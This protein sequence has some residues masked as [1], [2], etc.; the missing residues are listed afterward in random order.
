MAEACTRRVIEKLE[1]LLFTN[2]SYSFGG[3]TIY[4]YI[5]F[6]NNNDV[7]LSANWDAAGKTGAQILTDV[8]NMIQASIDA[9]HYGPWVLYIPTAYQTKLSEDYVSGY[10]KTIRT[11]LMEIEGL[12]DIKVADRLAANTVIMV[13]MTSD[14]VRLINGFAPKVLQWSTQGGLVHHFK[15]MAIQVPQMRADQA[16]NSGI[17]VLA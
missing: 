14:V 10:P 4:S 3:G 13:Q 15:V 17:T 2:T 16:G 6:T 1:D 9:K 8:L 5:S 12:T 11:R 7:T